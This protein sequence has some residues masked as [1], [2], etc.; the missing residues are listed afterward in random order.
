ML[1]QVGDIRR[2][3]VVRMNSDDD[4]LH[5]LESAVREH[6][7]QHGLVLTG[8]GSVTSYHGP[9]VT[10]EEGFFEILTLSGLIIAGRVHAHITFG[11]ADKTLGGH[12]RE[13]CHIGT[14]G[15]A[16]L[17]ETSEL[18]LTDWDRTGHI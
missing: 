12:V 16:T 14:F 15:V 11:D 17:A 9:L 7:I 3:I 18:D 5:C 6:R 10:V 13:G 2:L 4:V 1:T 8:V